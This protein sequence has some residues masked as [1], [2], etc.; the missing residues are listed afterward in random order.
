MLDHEVYVLDCYGCGRKLTIEAGQPSEVRSC[1]HCGAVLDI[2]W[3]PEDHSPS[4]RGENRVE[5]APVA[6]NGKSAVSANRYLGVK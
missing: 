5:V 3:R 1:P 4:K 6:A 2:D